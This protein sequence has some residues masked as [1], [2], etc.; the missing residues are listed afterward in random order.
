MSCRGGRISERPARLSNPP[1]LEEQAVSFAGPPGVVLNGLDEGPAD[2]HG[3]LRISWLTARAAA[4]GGA[5]SAAVAWP[6]TFWLRMSSRPRYGRRPAS[7]IGRIPS[8]FRRGALSFPPRRP[9]P[10]QGSA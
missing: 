2:V 6:G 5:A 7:E 9:V 10:A 1:R 8:T 3:L 4:P